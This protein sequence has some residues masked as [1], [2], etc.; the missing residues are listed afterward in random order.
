M[1]TEISAPAL[2]ARIERVCLNPE[3]SKSVPRILPFAV[4]LHQQA[5]RW[6]CWAKAAVEN[7]LR[8]MHEANKAVMKAKLRIFTSVPGFVRESSA[9][10]TIT[11][12]TGPGSAR[13]IERCSSPPSSPGNRAL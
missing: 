3:G 9:C 12:S 1:A 6:A 2:H 11:P 5:F 10:G 8:A 13:R 4:E 7:A